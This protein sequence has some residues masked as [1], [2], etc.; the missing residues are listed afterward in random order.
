MQDNTIIIKKTEKSVTIKFNRIEEK[1]SINTT[2]LDDLH[3]ALDE[4]EQDQN[5]NIVILEGHKSVFC[6]GMD[7]KEVVGMDQKYMN[8]VGEKS[9]MRYLNLLKRFTQIPKVV[10]SKVEGQVIGGGVGIVAASDLVIAN[11]QAQFSLPE[12]LWGLLPAMVAP[13]LIRRVG[14]QK[15]YSMTL[16]TIPV[17]A[18]EAAEISLVDIVSDNPNHAILRLTRRMKRLEASTIG[19][20]KEFFSKMWILSDEMEKYAASESY[21]K[22]SQHEVKQRLENFILYGKFPWDV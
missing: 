2:L 21:N 8:S 7:F 11:P 13:F 17:T 4:I 20:T 1:N 22:A 9:S 3:D 6:T 14:F 10:V 12:L 5:C 15:A 19:E 16:T 18:L